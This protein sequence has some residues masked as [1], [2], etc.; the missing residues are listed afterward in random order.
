[1]RFTLDQIAA[2]DSIVRLGSFNAAARQLNLTQPTVSQRIRE[3][4]FALGTVL[5]VRRGP[6]IKLTAEG[7]AL[8]GYARGMLDLSREVA[9][10]F[11]TG[12]PLKGSLR[13]GTTDTFAQICLLE[14]I[15]RV[16]QIYPGLQISVCVDN[17]GALSR[18]LESGEID[19][20]IIS[21]ANL[22]DRIATIGLGC[23]RFAWVASVST[24]HP[25]GVAEPSD[26]ASQ[27]VVVS[28][29]PSILHQ[30][31]LAWFTA[32]GA[33][34]SRIST[35][36]NLS[37]IVQMVSAGIAVGVLP[38]AIARN[39]V[40]SNRVRMI[41]VSP[42]LRDHEVSICYRKDS[43]SVALREITSIVRELIS[44]HHLFEV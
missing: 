33:A 3:L 13:F 21:Q 22:S 11:D 37:V 6:H 9:A 31:V 43:A 20:A 8:Q 41:R 17:S 16:E 25:A 18:L 40:A 38:V 29:P 32:A 36:N 1:M 23:N 27:H 15:G 28:A 44:G 26:F 10:R 4:E 14:M 2:F 42:P 35:C 30:T 7:Q 39:E 12:A 19:V 5:F 24:D 34:P